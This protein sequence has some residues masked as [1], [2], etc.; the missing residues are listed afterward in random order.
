MTLDDKQRNGRIS[1]DCVIVENFFGRASEK[2]GILAGKYTWDRDTFNLVIDVCFSLRNFHIML[3]PLREQDGQYYK[4]VLATLKHTS[5]ASID[6]G[7]RRQLRYRQQQVA[8]RRAIDDEFD[9]Y[10][11]L[12]ESQLNLLKFEHADPTMPAYSQQQA[13]EEAKRWSKE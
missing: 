3:H 4:E 11:G 10:D 1:T 7:R 2:C 6:R 8:I 9:E 5:E 12:S 13:D